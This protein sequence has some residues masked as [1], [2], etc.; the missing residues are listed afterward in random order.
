MTDLFAV[1]DYT[2]TGAELLARF[3]PLLKQA[4]FKA[5]PTF[6]KLERE[7][8]Q[9]KHF[10]TRAQ[11]TWANIEEDDNVKNL[12]KTW[13]KDVVRDLDSIPESGDTS[14]PLWSDD[15]W[16]TQW[17]QTS[18]RYADGKEFKDYKTA[19]ASYEQPKEFD[20]LINSR[21]KLGKVLAK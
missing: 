14:L 21:E 2:K 8:F 3:H 10:E 11:P 13:M 20:N 15:Y 12:A 16:R 6:Q 17:G 19:V 9:A 5:S 4:G 18:Y 7:R 1:H